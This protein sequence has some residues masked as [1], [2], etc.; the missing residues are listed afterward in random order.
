MRTTLGLFRRDLR[1]LVSVPMAV[2]VTLFIALIPGMYSWLNVWTYWDPYDQTQRLQVAVANEDTG[3]TSDLAGKL[4]VGD[5]MVDQLKQNTQLGWT[6]VDKDAAL[7]GVKSGQYY[8]AFVIPPTFSADLASLFTAERKTPQLQYYVNEKVNP[9]TPKV[10]DTG[11]TT[12]DNQVNQTFVQTVST[13]VADIVKETAQKEIDKGNSAFS[14]SAGA[15]KKAADAAT[16]VSN[17][18]ADID[19]ARTKVGDA[20]GTLDDIDSAVSAAQA[21]LKSAGDLAG[22]AR[23]SARS[24]GTEIATIAGDQGDKL[25]TTLSE[26]SAKTGAVA[27]AATSANTRVDGVAD[28][29][30]DV[31]DAEQ[32]AL[33]ALKATSIASDPGVAAILGDVSARIGNQQATVDTVRQAAATAT[34][35]ADGIASSTDAVSQAVTAARGDATALRTQADTDLLP[36]LGSGLDQA[37]Q[38]SD[39]LSAA[40][41]GAG[42]FTGQA[43]TLLKTFDTLLQESSQSVRGTATLLTALATDLASAQTDLKALQDSHAY[44]QL[45]DLTGLDSEALG[46]FM[47]APT[48]LQT[49]PIYPVEHYGSSV[50]PLYANLAIWIGAFMICMLF[51]L[52]MDPKD[53]GPL[54][55]RRKG[56]SKSAA[57]AKAGPAAPSSTNEENPPTH[58]QTFFA[59]WMVLSLIPLLQGLLICVGN[60]ILGVQTVNPVIYVLTGMFTSLVYFSIIYALSVSFAHIGKGLCIVLLTLQIPGASGMYPIELMPPFFRALYPFLPFTYGIDLMRETIGGFYDHEY[61]RLAAVM[62]LFVA[63]AFA[64]ALVARPYLVNLTSL[65][66]R[67]AKE[68]ELLATEVISDQAPTTRFQLTHLLAALADREEYSDVI[69]A[70]ANRFNRLYPKLKRWGL[71]AGGV[72]PLFLVFFSVTTDQKLTALLAWFVWAVVIALF[73]VAVEYFHDYVGNHVKLSEMTQDQITV[74]LRKIATR[75]GIKRAPHGKHAAAT[76]ASP[77]G[78]DSAAETKALPATVATLEPAAGAAPADKGDDE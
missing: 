22:K 45:Q 1:R 7:E 38:A 25:S 2:V 33:D 56:Q 47:S 40:L 44:Q 27:G 8:A 17:L 65:F 41:T 64:T 26:V 30:Q 34:T 31:I 35:A 50:A 76:A 29:L 28:S 11:A 13:K 49:E 43:R 71:I 23:T 62:L 66:T 59:R 36:A 74:I 78:G 52:E 5:Q 21:S 72:L 63:L 18:A 4:D 3:T 32:D 60:L 75:G 20:G 73:L 70:R 24:L 77:A 14:D 61:L 55:G 67:E 39:D 37:A 69:T 57:H 68:T 46:Q 10:T 15:V 51:N 16:D 54:P 9:I 12:L 58:V 53:T 6:F 19:A 42:T 48:K